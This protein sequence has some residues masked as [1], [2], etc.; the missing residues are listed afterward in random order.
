MVRIAPTTRTCLDALVLLFSVALIY[1]WIILGG[2]DVGQ[3]VMDKENITRDTETAFDSYY[4]KSNVS[5]LISI[6]SFERVETRRK[7][8]IEFLWG[9]SQLPG[10]I[11]AKIENNYKDQRYEEIR[12]LERIDRLSIEMEY[13]LV[14]YVYHF[15]PRK[16]NGAIIFY[17]Q[18]HGGDFFS[19]IKVIS[20]L[21]GKGYAVVGFSMP[22]LG[23]NTKPDVYFERFGWF[24]LNRHTEMKL[25]LPKN[26]HPLKYFLEPVI[27]VVNYLEQSYDYST[28]G[29]TGISG[30]GW[31]TTIVAAI[32]PRILVS[33]PVAGSVPV[34]LRS[35]DETDFGDYEQV[36][37]E[38]LRLANYLELYVLGAV[39]IGRSQLQIINMFDRCCFSGGKTTT[40]GAIVSSIVQ[41][42]DS[43]EYELHIDSSHDMHE[44]S[45]EAILLIDKKMREVSTLTLE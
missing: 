22:L 16:S 43:G 38:F 32:D 7:Q 3:R 44:I 6:D 27:Q 13:D 14:S 10:N 20:Q 30:G 25:L 29:M 42:L 9:Q 23:M 12:N 31:T 4:L 11:P 17:H 40:Y 24:H 36:V 34:Y 35:G 26:G 5:D 21:L 33:I 39:G 28:L 19:G 2:K 41:D 15:L 18:G 37:P 8:L 45:D 1:S